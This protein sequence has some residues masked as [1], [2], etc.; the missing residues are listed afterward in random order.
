MDRRSFLKNSIGALLFAGLS[1]NKVLAGVV[2]TLTP[3][4]PN[5]LLYLIQNKKGYWFVRGTSWIKLGKEVVNEEKYN[6]ETFKSL[7]IVHNDLADKRRLELW[8]E[9]KCG[10]GMGGGTGFPLNIVK[11]RNAQKIAIKSEGILN[12]FK[13][14]LKKEHARINGL[15]NAQLGI[16]Q[17]NGLKALD[18]SK[19]QR[20]DIGRRSGL[21]RVG[22]LASD[23]HKDNISKGLKGK[24]KSKEHK[25]KLSIFRTGKKMDETQKERYKL[26][27]K[28]ERNPMYGKTHTEETRKKISNNPAYKI[29]RIC[30]HCN[31]TIIGTNYFRHHGDRCKLNPNKTI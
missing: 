18:L 1:S 24:P 28:G 8:K 6:I 23:E 29:E 20:A 3:D 5:V 12:Y 13:S 21:S 30:P 31:K 22:R 4:S 10:G 26:L 9:Y 11:S 14:E 27:F 17:K 25:E 2:E 15:R 7:E 19:E 16:S